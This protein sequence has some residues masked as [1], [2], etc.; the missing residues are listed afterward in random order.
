MIVKV[1][2]IPRHRY[3][4]WGIYKKYVQFCVLGMASK[5]VTATCAFPG[6]EDMSCKEFCAI[7]KGCSNH[8]LLDKKC[9]E[10][11]LCEDYSS[12]DTTGKF[13]P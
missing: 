3:N 9:C 6:C 13:I 2:T 1:E 11:K 12:K 8:W 10:C 5:D 7:D 4:P